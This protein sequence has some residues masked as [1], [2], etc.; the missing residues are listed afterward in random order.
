MRHTTCYNGEGKIA[1]DD[2]ADEIIVAQEI[3]GDWHVEAK[4]R[5]PAAAP[6]RQAPT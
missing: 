4:A 3:N 6:T 2:E 5:F 1:R